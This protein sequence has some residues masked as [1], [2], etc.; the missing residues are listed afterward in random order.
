MA[1][2]IKIIM[3]VSSVA[4]FSF[5]GCTGGEESDA[6][7]PEM[8]RSET[9]METDDTAGESET[10]AESPETAGDTS[11]DN[12]GESELAVLNAEDLINERCSVCHTTDR[13]YKAGFDRERW[14][15][16]VDRMISK[17]AELN[18]AER[19]SVIEYLVNP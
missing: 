3:V 16:T 11:G 9:V 17:G 19:D 5:L 4:F 2:A 14:E 13:I 12:G 8:N 7:T 6:A 1:N 10:A 18:E 15:E